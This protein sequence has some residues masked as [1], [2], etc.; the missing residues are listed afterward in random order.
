MDEDLEVIVTEGILRTAEAVKLEYLH[1]VSGTTRK[2]ATFMQRAQRIR[3]VK[4][5]LFFFIHGIRKVLKT[6]F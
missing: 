1:V 2:G 3:R 6:S 5:K 4:P